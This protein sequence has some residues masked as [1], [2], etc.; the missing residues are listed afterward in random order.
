MNSEAFLSKEEAIVQLRLR[1]PKFNGNPDWLKEQL[2]ANYLHLL[3][4]PSDEFGYWMRFYRNDVQALL[5]LA[6]K[7]AVENNSF[8][9]D[10]W[11]L[12]KIGTSDRADRQYLLEQFAKVGRQFPRLAATAKNAKLLF[13]HTEQAVLAPA[14]ANLIGSV[15]VM[16]DQLDWVND[17]GE[18]LDTD[19]LTSAQWKSLLTLSRTEEHAVHPS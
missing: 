16:A 3:A 18:F 13:R 14:A 12:S 4:L 2:M 1:N 6:T 11:D 19:I 8:Q 15:Y 17:N 9:Q 7:I 10:G 5:T